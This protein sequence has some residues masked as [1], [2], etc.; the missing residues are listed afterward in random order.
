MKLNQDCIRDLL[1]YLEE[2]LSLERNI[3]VN[4]I[5]IKDYSQEDLIYTTQKLFEAGYLNCEI[6]NFI[7]SSIPFIDVSS[8]TYKGHQFLD[9]IRDNK[10]W[11]KTKGILSS[12]KS[13]SI[14]ILSET[15]SKVLVSLINQQLNV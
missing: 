11:S 1:L 10:V 8:L 3:T 6:I 2:N 13:V 4:N 5:K 12:F 14:E 9:T 15:A 7:T